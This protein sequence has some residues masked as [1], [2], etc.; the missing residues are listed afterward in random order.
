M[1]FDPGAC[2]EDSDKLCKGVKMGEGR[3]KECLMKHSD[4]LSEGCKA[5][6]FDAAVKKKENEAKKE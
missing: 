5:N 6:L 2:K 4:K 3:I 1:A